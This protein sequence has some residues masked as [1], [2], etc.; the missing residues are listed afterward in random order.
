MT[1]KSSG[2][3]KFSDIEN[4]FGQGTSEYGRKMSN[5]YELNEYGDMLLPMDEGIPTS[6][7][8]KFSDF[9][10]K[11]LNI[12]VDAYSGSSPVYQID[13]S[14]KTDCPRRTVGKRVSKSVPSTINS[15]KK[16][17]IHVNKRIG[18]KTQEQASG[19]NQVAFK[20][21][22]WNGADVKLYVGGQGLIAGGGGKGGAG[23]IY[24]RGYAY[25]PNMKG[26]DGTSALGIDDTSIEVTVMASNHPLRKSSGTP[27]AIVAGCGGGGGGAGADVW[28][29]I[30]VVWPNWKWFGEYQKDGAGNPICSGGGSYIGEDGTPATG[31]CPTPSGWVQKLYDWYIVTMARYWSAG[32]G[33]G[34]GAG[35]P[36]G[37]GGKGGTPTGYIP[38]DGVTPAGDWAGRGQT[39]GAAAQDGNKPDDGLTASNLTNSGR[40]GAGG[41]FGVVSLARGG[42]GGY[43]GDYQSA[44]MVGSTG[45]SWYTNTNSSNYKAGTWYGSLGNPLYS[46]KP[47]GNDNM[48]GNPSASRFKET[49]GPGGNPGYAVVCSQPWNKY[50]SYHDGSRVMGTF[51]EQQPIQG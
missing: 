32:G 36:G 22:N 3:L 2:T 48:I 23:G 27:G 19:K 20:T 17:I 41:F 31:A 44:S 42:K 47:N 6:G 34:G 51:A 18:S 25:L 38:N 26:G 1:I 28:A 40:S 46:P 43:G 50:G 39:Q 5:Y 30:V 12:I 10:G 21:G 35:L 49:G 29:W 7:G 13:A 15:S 33:G 9:Y 24:A 11:K 8:I 16:V 4:E 37:G 45:D 14:N